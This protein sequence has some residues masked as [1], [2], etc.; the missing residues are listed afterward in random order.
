[1]SWLSMIKRFANTIYSAIMNII[2]IPFEVFQRYVGARR[3]VILFL[4]PNLLIFST[5]TLFPVFLNIYYSFTGGSK[6]FLQD[7][8]FVGLDN[9]SRIFDCANYLEPNTCREDIFWSSI[10]RTLVYVGSSVVLTLLVSVITALVL[11]RPIRFKG[12]FRSVFFYPVMLSPV[13]IALTWRWIVQREGL[14][15]AVLKSLNI[16]S[17]NFMVSPD[18]ATFWV[19]F[20]GVWASMGFYSLIIL[21]GLQSIPAE[22]YEAAKIDGA[23]EFASFRKVT[24]PLLSPTILVVLVL[25][26]IRSVQVFDHVYAFTTGGPGTATKYLVQYIVETG[27]TTYP[28]SFGMA[29]AGSALMLLVLGSITLI[30]NR[31]SRRTDEIY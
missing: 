22:L 4:L 3:M 16:E 25:V 19:I 7:R 27:F 28:R 24:L 11:N 23:D 2:G 21:A 30:Q 18:W 9:Y 31:L 10:P 29:A 20:V 15:N 6:P 14:M 13:V 5:F 1:M 26:T 8:P 17:V 12:F